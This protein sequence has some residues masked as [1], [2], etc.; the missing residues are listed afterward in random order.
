M[1]SPIIEAA[2]FAAFGALATKLL[3]FSDACELGKRWVLRAR[4]FTYWLPFFIR[5]VVG[6]GL[7]VTYMMSGNDL[8]PIVAVNVG[9]SAPL[10]LQAMVDRKVPRL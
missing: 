2:C 9:I 4:S 1:D 3:A 7:A 6:A 10:I 5:P 8:S